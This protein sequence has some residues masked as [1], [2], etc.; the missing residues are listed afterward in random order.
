MIL[1]FK[2]LVP[3]KWYQLCQNNFTMNWFFKFSGIRD[4]VI[5]SDGFITDSGIYNQTEG[6]FG[7]E[8]YY[9]FA[10]AKAERVN[11]YLPDDQK[12]SDIINA[13]LIY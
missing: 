10:S 1:T 9:Q 5:R 2:D 12:V 6:N 13:Y 8:G 4:G 3:G 7:S 11:P